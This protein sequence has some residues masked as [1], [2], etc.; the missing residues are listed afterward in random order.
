MPQLKLFEESEELSVKHEDALW[1]RGFKLIAGVDEAGR[2]PLAGPVVAC[3]CILPR[4]MDIDGIKDSKALTEKE[5]RR[6]SDLLTSH[7]DVCYATAVITH[8]VIDN[9]N[10]L[11]ASLLAMQRAIEALSQVPD[12]VLVD[13]RDYPTISNPGRPVV[14][15]DAL[16][17]C[18][19]AASIIAKVLRDSIM[20]DLHKQYPQY[21]F[22]SHKG[23]GTAQH[24]K[25]IKQYGLSPIHRKSFAP[26]SEDV[27][28]LF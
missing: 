28:T 13:G 19:G 20:D 6:L 25:A 17:Q 5:R 1:K 23:Y 14:H 18:I 24:R 7:P 9:I 21:G 15:G 10:I 2:G 4:G 16:C 3:A 11:R 26:I 27:P 12:Y 8:D 22:D